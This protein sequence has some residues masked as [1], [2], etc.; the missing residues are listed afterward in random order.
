M[1]L[2]FGRTSALLAQRALDLAFA[3]TRGCVLRLANQIDVEREGG[4]SG[5]KRVTPSDV[6][7]CIRTIF[8]PQQTPLS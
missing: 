6:L 7:L 4:F 8:V 3:Q 2:T 5:K 1:R